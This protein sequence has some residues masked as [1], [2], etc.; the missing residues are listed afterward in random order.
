MCRS[1]GVS[2]TPGRVTWL[3]MCSGYCWP[4]TSVTLVTCHHTTHHMPLT[5]QPPE[6]LA[7]PQVVAPAVRH[8][9][10]ARAVH[11]PTHQVPAR[12]VVAHIQL[13]EPALGV[14]VVAVAATDHV[15]LRPGQL[16]TCHMSRL[17]VMSRM[18]YLGVVTSVHPEVE[19]LDV[20]GLPVVAVNLV[21]PSHHMPLK[22]GLVLDGRHPAVGPRGGNVLTHRV[23]LLKQELS[24]SD[25]D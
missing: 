11:G 12:P 19:W 18:T 24:F 23:P 22:L 10:E 2:V 4:L 14:V 20:S 21:E 13:A 9:G 25:H 1:G 7:G 15:G 16:W 5:A 8:A 17:S 3:H 6:A